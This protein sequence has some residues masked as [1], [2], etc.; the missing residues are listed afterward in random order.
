[1][2]SA[3]L[4]V[5]DQ[6]GI[7]FDS[8]FGQCFFVSVESVF[9]DIDSSRAFNMDDSGISLLDQMISGQIAALNIIH[10]NIAAGQVTAVAIKKDQ[11]HTSF[12]K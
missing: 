11:R 5:D 8:V 1:M 12:M 9:C 2:I 7:K 3:Q 10:K 6:G 4:I